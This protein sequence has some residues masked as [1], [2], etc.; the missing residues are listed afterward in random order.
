MAPTDW[1]SLVRLADQG[2]AFHIIDTETTGLSPSA[3]RVIELATVTLRHGKI[4]DRFETFVDPGVP[5]PA[6][7]TQI[8]G[9]RREMLVGAPAPAQ[10]YKAWRDYLGTGGHFVAHNAGFD[11]DF[12]RTEFARQALDWP[13]EQSVCTVRLARHCLPRLRKHGLGALIDHYG[14]QVSDRHRAL[15]DVEAT[16]ELFLKFLDQLRGGA[17]A[18]AEPA[19]P[20]PAELATPHTAWNELVKHVRAQSNATAALLAQHATVAA[21]EPD[22]ALVLRVTPVYRPRFTGDARRFAVVEAAARAVFGDGTYLR[23][24]G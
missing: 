8:T 7:I 13:F 9:I 1:A 20:A 16:A 23:I 11:W 6:R 22:G 21:H 15:A 19:R 17:A 5:I 18:P 12:L 10:A 2:E 24:E 3:N 4:V 14:I